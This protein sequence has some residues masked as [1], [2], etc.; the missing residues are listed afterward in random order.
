MVIYILGFDFL[1][2]HIVNDINKNNNIWFCLYL[3]FNLYHNPY[4]SVTTTPRHTDKEKK[5]LI[6]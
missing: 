6:P 4:T 5:N 2:Q 3:R 1:P